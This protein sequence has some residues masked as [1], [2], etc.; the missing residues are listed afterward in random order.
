MI[1]NLEV[2]ALRQFHRR[3]VGAMFLQADPTPRPRH[4]PE[5]PVLGANTERRC[6]LAARDAAL[7]SLMLHAGLRV[8][9]AAGL[10][11]GAAALSERRGFVTV[12]CGRGGKRTEVLLNRAA[13]A[14]PLFPGR[15]TS[16]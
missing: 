1:V 2:D 3:A 15:G 8:S 4:L 14:G 9:E 6:V 7:V 16:A 10:D 5:G 11:F 13:C 12:R